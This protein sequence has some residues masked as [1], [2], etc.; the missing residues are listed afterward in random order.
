M[1][2]CKTNNPTCE[3]QS[4]DV[5]NQEK[6]IKYVRYIFKEDGKC[7][8]KIQWR[9]RIVKYVFVKLNEDWW[10]W[11]ILLEIKERVLKRFL[12]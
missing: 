2:A 6:K 11:K 7:Y 12:I 8:P 4:G 1:D 9:I 3:Q 5:Q 10:N